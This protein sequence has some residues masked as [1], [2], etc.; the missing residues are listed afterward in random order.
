MALSCLINQSYR[1]NI[2]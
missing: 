1:S 2:R